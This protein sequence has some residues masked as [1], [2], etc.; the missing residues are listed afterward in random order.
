MLL[1]VQQI[2][3][4]VTW[5]LTTAMRTLVVLIPLAALNVPATMDLRAM[6]SAAQV[7]M[8]NHLMLLFWRFTSG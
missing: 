1:F 6:G 3:M 8:F 5:R 7:R 2:S 4:S